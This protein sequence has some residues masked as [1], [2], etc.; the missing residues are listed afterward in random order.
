MCVGTIPPVLSSFLLRLSSPLLLYRSWEGKLPYKT[1]KSSN[2]CC[3]ALNN[4]DDD[5][6]RILELTTTFK[7]PMET[8]F[9]TVVNS[10]VLESKYL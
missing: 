7:F 6:N 5:N 9:I 1:I 3:A 4:S 2:C 8:Q 10:M